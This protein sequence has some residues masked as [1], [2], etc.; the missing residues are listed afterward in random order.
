MQ[1]KVFS[2]IKGPWV[3]L[4]GGGSVPVTGPSVPLTG[5]SVPL[6]DFFYLFKIVGR[7]PRAFNCQGSG[8]SLRI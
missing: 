8:V 5:G 1:L 4:T 7:G 2:A 6:A 3:P